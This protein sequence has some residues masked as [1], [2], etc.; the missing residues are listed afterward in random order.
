MAAGVHHVMYHVVRHSIISKFEFGTAVD[1]GRRNC[2]LA[3]KRKRGAMWTCRLDD[4]TL[5]FMELM[6]F[7]RASCTT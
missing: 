3:R 1:V 4:V 6:V 5:K 7:W 2:I